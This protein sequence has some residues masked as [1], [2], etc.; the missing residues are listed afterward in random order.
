MVIRGDLELDELMIDGKSVEEFK[1]IVFGW[2]YDIFSIARD[3]TIIRYEFVYQD[4]VIMRV[5]VE[6]LKRLGLPRLDG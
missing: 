2:V 5:E 4:L 1:E 3:E 6:E